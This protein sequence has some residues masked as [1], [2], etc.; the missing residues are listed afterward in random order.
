MVH[1]IFN[2]FLHNGIM[3]PGWPTKW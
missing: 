2:G 1:F 3:P